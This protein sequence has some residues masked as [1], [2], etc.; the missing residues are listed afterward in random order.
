MFIYIYIYIYI[1]DDGTVTAP[2][3]TF[4]KDFKE[5]HTDTSVLFSLTIPTEKIAEI[6]A[7]KGGLHKR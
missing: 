7:E 3:A 6:N 1:Q 5:N 2:V 4:I